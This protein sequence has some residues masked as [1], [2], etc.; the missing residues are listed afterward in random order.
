MKKSK[1]VVFLG[2]LVHTGGRIGQWT[3]PLNVGYIGSHAQQ[4]LPGELEIR[5]FKRPEHLI[6]ALNHERPSVVGLSHYVWNSNLNRHV[7]GIVKSLHPHALTV[8]GG[9]NMT[10]LNADTTGALAF[11]AQQPACDAFVLNQGE[12]GFATLLEKFL[13]C[14]ASLPRWRQEPT[15]GSLVN[16]DGF[17]GAVHVTP[18]LPPLPDLDAIPSPYLT[19]LLD[20]FF[21]EP[22]TPILETNRSCP[23][24]CTFCA[25]GIGAG[26][27]TRFSDDRVFAEIDYVSQR[28]HKAMN[29]F[30]ADANFSILPRDEKI[31]EKLYAAHR[32]HGFPGH[33]SIQWNK[34]NPERVMRVAKALRGLSDIT[35]TLQSNNPKVLAA[36]QRTNLPLEKVEEIVTTL[37]A[38]EE[39]ITVFSELILGLPEETLAS[40]MAANRLLMDKGVEMVNF[41]LYLLPGTAMNTPDSRARY[42]RTVGWRIQDGA[43]GE[44][45]GV[46]VIDGQEIV[47]ATTTM[48][49]EE[50]RS[51]RFTHALIQ[52]MW[53]RQYFIDYLKLLQGYGIHPLDAILAVAAAFRT[54]DGP[55]A[56]LMQWFRTDHDL[57]NFPDFASLSAYW[58]ADDPFAR[59]KSGQFGKLNFQLT[60]KI[61]LDHLD[62]FLAL[63]RQVGETLLTDHQ[64]PD[65][66]RAQLAEVLHL[67]RE[68]RIELTGNQA[69]VSQKRLDLHHDFLTWRAENRHG[70]PRPAPTPCDL[71]LPETQRHNLER[72][73]AQF[74]ADNLHATLRKMSEYISSD[75]FFYKMRPARQTP[76]TPS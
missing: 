23:Y 26:K 33:C 43:F 30:L 74:K 75:D 47:L 54:T 7:Y 68:L 6:E 20:P 13:A 50:L 8:G 15:P 3:F 34:G 55:L 28:C 52:F 41:N 36:I 53:S 73:L 58:C 57:E 69:L 64:A 62:P 72:Q 11:F 25:W 17:G 46:R 45:A 27:L 56:E 2:D 39:K 51:C 10:D 1:T 71:Y 29:L 65:A 19:G 48:S 76:E 67:S 18:P 14:G 35:A 38:G 37:R 70:T 9:P 60:F 42:F 63:L 21:A 22:M 59:L 40:H 24:R 16:A 32:Q 4:S 31:A 44:Y 12:V 61:L 49:L 66:A 5:L